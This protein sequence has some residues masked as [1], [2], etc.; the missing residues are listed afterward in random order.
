VLG[1][2][3]NQDPSVGIGQNNVN[4]APGT[5]PASGNTVYLGWISGDG[6]P[7][8]AH[9]QDQGATWLDDTNVGASVVNVDG[10]VGIRHSV[11]PAV[12]AGDD[13][14]AAYGFL[15]TGPAI[16]SGGTCDPL[17][18]GNCANIWHA[19]VATTYD[20]GKHWGTIDTTP[21]KAVQKGVICTQGTTCA[22]GRNLLDF[23]DF[24]VDSQGRGLYAYDD[25]VGPTGNNTFD[26][27][28]GGSQATIA[29]Q[30]GGQRLFSFFDTPE[31]HAPAAPQAVSANRVTG[32]PA[33]IL[34]TWLEP[35]SGGATITGY[36]IYRGTASGGENTMTPVGSTTGETST[37]FLDT[38][39]LPTGN[40]FY[41]ITAVNTSGES[42]FCNEPGIAVINGGP[43]AAPYVSVDGAGAAGNV[44]TDPTMGELTIQG[45]NIGEP[46]TSCTDNSLTFVMKVQ[47]LDPNGT[48]MTVL[49]PNSGWQ[50]LF[51]ITDTNGN[52]E[53]VFVE[54][55]TFRADVPSATRIGRRD[56]TPTGTQDTTVCSNAPAPPTTCS[57]I[58][59]TETGDGTIT[60]KLNVGALLNFPAPAAPATGVTFN[61]DAR[62]AGTK[63]SSIGGNA[64]L[65][66]G[67]FL[68][69]V[70]ATA[71]TGTYTRVGN[72]FCQTG[73]PIAV[74]MATP[75]NPVNVNQPVTFDASASHEPTG[76]CGT[77]NSYTLNFGDGSP[78][79]TQSTPT[80]GGFTH[81]YTTPGDY[82]ARLTVMDTSGLVSNSVTDIISVIG[83]PPPLTKVV[84]EKTHGTAGT[85]DVPLQKNATTQPRGVECRT[86]GA[87]GNHTII[88]TFMNNLVS[89]DSAAV[90]LGPGSVVTATSGIGPA[91]NQYTVNLTGVTNAQYVSVALNNAHDTAGN[92]GAVGTTM[93]ALLGDVNAT[94]GVDGNDVAAVQSQTRQPVN[95]DAQARFD[96][97]ASGA[98]DGNDVAITQGQTRTSLPSTP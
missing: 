77:I 20:G 78:P 65:L 92:I 15:G 26:G 25:G 62:N 11:F 14:R 44:P 97:N 5:T 12:V 54:L 47:T 69:T 90:V 46:F 42:A 40:Y 98:I 30:S 60:I 66:A 35:D 57:Q 67:A 86:G 79:V 81:A 53:T 41:H 37:Q 17:G 56:P 27:Q 50:I 45:V 38:T 7:H 6:T 75:P 68:E 89:V 59:A 63:L 52:P 31:P 1:S 95:S 4:K 85:F 58:S 88:F 18:T 49:P 76:A 94:G 23:T 9:S 70:Q 32:P 19:Y 28:S 74:L 10:T 24:G 51:N 84:S 71:K 48:G 91:A 16:N 36:N 55:D 64:Y 29:R 61:W 13:N 82:P 3:G 21:N 80:G 87:N 34:V 2:T 96:V 73:K 39:V 22:G 72:T 33:G 93:G 43:C 83:T 8:I